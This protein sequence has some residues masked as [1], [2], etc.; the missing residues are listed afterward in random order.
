MGARVY[1][2]SMG[3]FTSPDPQVGGNENAY[4]HPND[5]INS[6]DISGKKRTAKSLAAQLL[7]KAKIVARGIRKS[8][9]GIHIS[10]AA[11][12]TVVAIGG[13]LLSY[14]GVAW[15]VDAIITA[16]DTPAGVGLGLVILLAMALGAALIATLNYLDWASNGRGIQIG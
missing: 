9:G 2:S 10:H 15:A 7:G 12:A 1:N 14:M 6:S 11:V 4:S 16:I 5:P 8:H 3:R 13:L